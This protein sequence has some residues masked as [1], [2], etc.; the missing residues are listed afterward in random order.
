MF[1]AGKDAQENVRQELERTQL[2]DHIIAVYPDRK[3]KID[4]VMKF[5]G[6]GLQ[7]NEAVMLVTED[8]K[9]KKFLGMMK[10][11]LG[12]KVSDLAA[13][14]DILVKTT[15]DVYFPDDSVNISRI[16]AGWRNLGR[17][18]ILRDKDGLRVFADVKAF[19]KHGFK[20]E[21]V[22]YEATLPKELSFPISAICAY[23]SRDVNTLTQEQMRVLF[24][25]HKWVR[26]RNARLLLRHELPDGTDT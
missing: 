19:F 25:H 11:Q 12:S 7:R 4:E 2:G 18:S 14:G 5:L 1:Y 26:M 10:R 20:N 24:E 17:D 6:A 22:E 21:L 23:E 13:K 9:K 3:T 16:V 8:I 15:S